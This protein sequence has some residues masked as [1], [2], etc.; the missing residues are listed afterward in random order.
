MRSS[1][2]IGLALALVSAAPSAAEAFCGFY[3]SG[4][5]GELYNNATQVVL[6]R[7][8]TRTVLSMQN[9]YQ[10]PA[11]DFA[12]VVPVPVVLQKDNVKT[13]PAGV[14]E[15][16]DRLAAP[17]LV[18]YWEQDPC[19]TPVDYAARTTRARRPRRA[20]HKSAKKKPDLGVTI[21]AKF[22]V[23]EYKIL[24]LSAKD[25]TG[26]DKWLRREGYKIPKGAEPLLR[27][28]VQQGMKFFVA[29]VD[30]NK[31]TKGPHGVEL[32]P[33]R[34]YYDTNKFALPVR[35]GL[36]NSHGAQD[37]IVHI[38]ADKRYEVANYK[39]VFIPTNL[40]VTNDARKH[41]GEF[42]AA[43]FDAT[44]NKNPGAV[45]TE[46]SW[47]SSSCDPCP[48]PPLGYRD[49]LYLGRDVLYKPVNAIAVPP[50]K[51][52]QMKKKV[53]RR[54][55]PR[56]W[57]RRRFYGG[58]VLT[59]LHVRYTK[60]SLKDDLV[61]KKAAAV[62]GGRERRSGPKGSLE[63]GAKPSYSNQFQARYAI[64]H[65]WTGP[66]N[67]KNPRFGRWG[68]PPRRSAPKTQAALNLAFAPRGKRKLASF[69]TTDIKEL[70]VKAAPKSATPAPKSA[71]PAP[72]PRS[73]NNGK[74]SANPPAKTTNKTKS[75]TKKKKK[76]GC[77]VMGAD[78][79][80]GSVLLLLAAALLVARRRRR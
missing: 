8:K 20:R 41:F 54:R 52:P 4:A 56:R 48:T 53:L 67:C 40:D 49:L 24:I 21:E 45:V 34:F 64:R 47:T 68:G 19:A 59:R 13:L 1:F 30:I 15:R 63:H 32:S 5:D 77:A 18:E 22:N 78:G 23:K 39:N 58:M 51:A 70:S 33:L 55:R 76:K 7:H 28:Y 71:T 9:N 12:M 57:R 74:T 31:V 38:L 35:L 2:A 43:L 11:K 14:F 29:K 65:K 6:M 69:V 37:L 42:Y 62:V 60:N 80:A 66:V 46:Y 44:L 79:G 3:V 25:S 72:A 10:G 73:G 17:R 27:P 16:V 26:L 61:F 50:S 75:T 36:M